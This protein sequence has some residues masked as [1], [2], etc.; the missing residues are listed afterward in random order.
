MRNQNPPIFEIAI[1]GRVTWD[2]HSLNNEGTIGNVSEPRTVV[3]WDGTKTDGVSGEMIKHI[4]AYWTWLQAKSGELRLCDAC[5]SFRPQRA[6]AARRGLP[7]DNARAVK[8][9]ISRCVL[10]DLHGFL[11]QKPTV[12][13]QSVVEFGWIV[14]IPEKVHRDIH[15]H[16]RHAVAE[17]GARARRKVSEAEVADQM[18]Y[19]RPSR[20]G[21]YAFASLFQPWRI[22]LNEVDYSY[23]IN[24]N[25]RKR[26]YEL[27]LN[28]Y[29]WTFK[30]PDG[31][32]TTTRYPHI[33]GVEGIVLV[34]HQA[35]PVPMLSPL[36]EEYREVLQKL[37]E[38]Q[39]VEVKRFDDLLALVSILDELKRANPLP[40]GGN[41]LTRQQR[42]TQSRGRRS[43]RR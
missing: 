30:R 37:A 36:R 34:S 16:A 33:G 42:N 17:R 9:A 4:H 3:L 15:V 25:D 10:C 7:K 43:R 26:R 2:L 41:T 38:K 21:I 1:L 18:V 8:I 5:Q 28:A 24:L 39:G 31:A 40:L 35:V 32:M 20:S 12:H 13:R 27:A 11:V 6:D 19:H 14:G 23:A 29:E 22:G